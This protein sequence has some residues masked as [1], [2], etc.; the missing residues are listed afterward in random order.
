M[1]RHSGGAMSRSRTLLAAVVLSGMPAA[2]FASAR[3][4]VQV[5]DPVVKVAIVGRPVVSTEG[6][7]VANHLSA[8]THTLE[9]RGADGQLAHSV[10]RAG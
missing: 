9:F 7:I 4:V 8:G 10:T 5:S 6:R 3:L 2:A 1:M